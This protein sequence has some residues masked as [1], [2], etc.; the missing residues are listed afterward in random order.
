[1]RHLTFFLFAATIALLDQ[2]TKSLI[3]TS[4]AFGQ[5]WPSADWPVKL[6]H[7]SNSGAA[8]G[9]LEGQGPILTAVGVI[10][11]AAI[12]GYYVSSPFQHRVVRGGLGLV[13]GGAIGNL[14][15]RFTRGEVT[16]FI[17]F[18]SYPNFNLADSSIVVG[19]IAIAATSILMPPPR[20]PETSER[21]GRSDG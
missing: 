14:V 5:S 15:D 1:M 3:R 10:V 17:D 4:L 19:L 7:G 13:L 16:D 6:T 2:L 18:P 11:V 8:F 20:S 9:I 12:V 21:P